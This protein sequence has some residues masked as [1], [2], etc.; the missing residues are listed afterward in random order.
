MVLIFLGLTF[1]QVHSK[2]PYVIGAHASSTGPG[3]FIGGPMRDGIIL[4]ADLINEAGGINGHPIKLIFYDDGGDPSRAVLAVKKLIDGDKVIAVVGG[5]RS[6]NILA[7]SPYVEKTGVP[8][9]SLGAATAI[10]QPVKKWTFAVAH[11]NMLATRKIIDYMVK[12][13]IRK[14]AFLPDNTAYGEDAYKSFMRQKPKSIDVPVRETFGDKDTDFT[15]Q[16][17]KAKAAGVE[18]VVV[19]TVAP[20]AAIIMKNALMLGMGIPFFHTHGTAQIQYPILAGEASKLMRMPSGRLPV[21]DELSDADPQKPVL[22]AFRTEHVKRYKYPASWLGG[23]GTD[24]IRIVAQAIKRAGWPPNKGKIL[25]EIEKTRNFVG[26]N[27]T[28]NISPTNHN[29][30]AYESMVMLRWEKGHFVLAE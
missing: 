13:K 26:L 30:L 23:H 8:Y 15:P 19:W 3:A 1:T 14:V 5:S 28:Y 17:T 16:L 4:G 24:A 18:A 12:H 29:G 9:V 11:T 22:L 10:T 7:C 20:P 25:N 6:G 27:G 2:E 21:V